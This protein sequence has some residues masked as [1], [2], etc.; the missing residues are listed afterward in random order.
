[1]QRTKGGGPNKQQGQDGQHRMTSQHDME[2]IFLEQIQILPTIHPLISNV[3]N[4]ARLA[5]GQ[6][7]LH[8]ASILFYSGHCK[9]VIVI[10]I[11]VIIV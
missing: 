11:I 7:S 1:M 9:V 6:V 5:E 8:N 4:I 3:D 2:P 10:V